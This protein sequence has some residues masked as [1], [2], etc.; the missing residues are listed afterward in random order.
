M[1]ESKKS[2]KN[3]FERPALSRIQVHMKHVVWSK[4]AALAV[5]GFSFIGYQPTAMADLN[6]IFTNAPAHVAIPRRASIIFIQCDGLGLGDLSCYGQSKFQTPNIDRLAA[7]GIRFT[8][9]YAGSGASSPARASLLTGMDSRHLR[10]RADAEIPLG[11]DQ[12]TVAQVLRNAGYR[13]DMIGEWILGDENSPG[14]PW[15]KGF[16]SFSGYFNPADA[17]NFYCD[18]V[19]RYSPAALYN[20]TN[21]PWSDFIGHEMIYNN[22]KADKS[23]FIPQLFSTAIV[24]FARVHVPDQRNSYQP[25]FIMVD[26]KLPGD[27]QHLRL[28]TDAPYSEESWS[29]A[30]KNRAAAV[31][32]LDGYIGELLDGL[33]TYRMTNNVAIFLSSDTGPQSTNI[34][35]TTP[36]LRGHRG[37]LY[38][39]ALRVPLI[40]RWPLRIPAGKTSDLPCAAWDFLP[41]AAE[42]AFAKPPENLDGI[43]FVPALTGGAQTN[44]HQALFW[45]LSG[46][47][48]VSAAYVDGWKAVQSAD[49]QL[50]VYDLKTD[51]AE[52]KPLQNPEMTSEFTELLKT[53]S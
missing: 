26:F 21:K 13:T 47:E 20:G 25:F 9:Y 32:R 40:V 3:C 24:N 42:I 36:G 17:A 41:T 30:D 22:T 23:V 14:A 5:L 51:P 44:R 27:S 34:F 19:W 15:K 50:D 43:S 18:Y 29:Q 2:E 46:R 1:M 4:L 49:G 6:S 8:S 38:E 39:G 35:E 33:Q 16:E 28:P 45:Q 53:K 7:E 12:I 48:P 52:K 11:P 37:E 10:Q 31:S